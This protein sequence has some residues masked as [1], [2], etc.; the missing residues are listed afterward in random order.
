M[1]LLA[2][3]TFS[4]HTLVISLPIWVIRQRATKSVDRDVN[5]HFD[6]Q[7]PFTHSVSFR[8][9]SHATLVASPISN[10]FSVWPSIGV[11]AQCSSV[12]CKLL[13]TCIL[14]PVC[15]CDHIGFTWDVSLEFIRGDLVS[16]DSSMGEQMY[17]TVCPPCGPGPI[18]WL[19]TLCQRVLSQ[20]GRKWHD[21]PAR[22]P[23][24]DLW[25]SRRKAK[26]QPCTDDGWK[27][28]HK[29]STH[30]CLVLARQ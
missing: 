11:G 8:Q 5:E 4:E 12:Y 20:H 25:T 16:H 14:F 19:I 18:P 6:R 1:Q 27:E 9:V 28:K 2:F 23:Y 26:I 24:Y 7:D 17:L 10:S 13:L 3:S 29:M 30:S 21:F 15:V 22:A